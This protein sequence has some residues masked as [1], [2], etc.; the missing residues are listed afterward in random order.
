MGSIDIE[1]YYRSFNPLDIMFK[2]VEIDKTHYMQFS[3]EFMREYAEYLD[4]SQISWYNKNLSEDFMREFKDK[5]DWYNATSEQ[6]LGERFI[7]EMKYYVAW[8][9]I[10]GFQVMNLDMRKRYS[11]MVNH[12]GIEHL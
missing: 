9:I 3:E 7:K 6:T 8:N 10:E 5:I 4:W 11:D 1:R 2:K 12:G